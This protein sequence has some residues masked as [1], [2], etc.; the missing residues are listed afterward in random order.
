MVRTGYHPVDGNVFRSLFKE[1]RLLHGGRYIDDIDIFRS[2]TPYIRGSGWFTRYA[3]PLFKKYIAPNL[4]DFGSNFLTDITSG[5][6][7]KSSAKKRGL[8]SLTKTIKKVMTGQGMRKRSVRSKVKIR[9]PVKK[10]PSN[11]KFGGKRIKKKKNK[12]KIKNR[13]RS[14]NKFSKCI[15]DRNLRI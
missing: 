10:K 4:I 11:P 3:I 2:G 13:T 14:R 12:K 15:F 7:A 6:S 5:E 1:E 9:K 8:Q